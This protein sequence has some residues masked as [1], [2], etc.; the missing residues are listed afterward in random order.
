M[1]TCRLHDLVSYLDDLL[2]IHQFQ[3]YPGAHN[4]LQLEGPAEVG[5]LFAAV[6]ACEAVI[7]EAAKEGPALLLVHHGLLWGGAMPFRG[8]FFRKLK[9]CMDAGLAIYSSHLPLDQ[10]PELGNNV[11]L[12]KELGFGASEPFLELRGRPAG[13]RIKTEIS[14]K[15]LA[16]RLAGATGEPPHL[17][18]GGKEVCRNIGIVTG[19]AGGEVASAAAC[20]VDTLIT[21]EGPHWSYTAAEELGVNLFYAGH[22]ATETFG[23]K[24]LADHCGARFDLPNRF[25]PHPSGL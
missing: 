7:L 22:Y 1:K 18:P 21:G 15:E 20:G 13:L 19:G 14:R 6:D 9:T 11:L 25:L 12:A 17:A 4:G 24:A 16:E 2:A 3:D 10:H 8:A 23:V 5:R